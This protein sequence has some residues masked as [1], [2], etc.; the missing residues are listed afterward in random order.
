MVLVV[1]I[2][3]TS[4]LCQASPRSDVWLVLQ[5]CS[6][7][8]IHADMVTHRAVELDLCGIGM[9]EPMKSSVAAKTY[10]MDVLENESRDAVFRVERRRSRS[11]GDPAGTSPNCRMP[12]SAKRP[13]E[14]VNRRVFAAD[15][16]ASRDRCSRRRSVARHYST[17][18]KNR[19]LATPPTMLGVPDDSD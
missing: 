14:S 10:A 8:R 12:G 13:S 17:G 3:V 2:D 15:L 16:N 7:W 9:I 1:Q 4:Q 6:L 11:A 18:V 5:K 19:P